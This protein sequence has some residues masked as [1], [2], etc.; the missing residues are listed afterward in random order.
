MV[1]WTLIQSLVDGKLANQAHWITSSGLALCG[2]AQVKIEVY[3]GKVPPISNAHYPDDHKD[4]CQICRNILSRSREDLSQMAKKYKP[5]L[6]YWQKEQ[7]LL[8]KMNLKFAL[9]FFFNQDRIDKMII[10]MRKTW[11]EFYKTLEKDGV[12]ARLNPDRYKSRI[13]IP[14]QMEGPVKKIII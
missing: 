7:E 4:N 13:L 10:A 11:E 1:G 9:A 5:E 3:G 8:E 12:L 6:E 2:R 14:G